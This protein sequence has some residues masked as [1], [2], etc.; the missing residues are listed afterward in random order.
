MTDDAAILAEFACS[1]D[2]DDLPESVVDRVRLVVSDTVGAII[3]GVDT[4]AVGRLVDRLASVE[5][6]PGTVLGREERLHPASAAMVNGTAGTVLELDE[7]HK[8]AAGHPAIHVIPALFATTERTAMSVDGPRFTAAVVAGYEVAVRVGEAATPLAPG[9]HPHGVW[10]VVGAVAGLA[11]LL[12]LDEQTATEAIRMAPNHAQHTR[13]EAAM[14]GRT[15][16]NTYAGMV[17]PDAIAVVDQAIA[18][19]TGLTD[20]LTAHLERLAHEGLGNIDTGSLGTRWTVENGY[21]KRH[22]ACR[23]T[24]P[25]IDAIDQLEQ[26]GRLLDGMIERIDI[27]TY[28]TAASLTETAPESP[29]AARFSLPFAVATRIHHGHANKDAFEQEAITSEVIDLAERVTIKS[30]EEFERAL[31]DERGARV[32]VTLADGTARPA[33]V[34]YAKGD[35][36]NPFGR[37]DLRDKFVGLVEPVLGKED[38]ATLWSSIHRLPDVAPTALVEGTRPTSK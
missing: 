7:G 26:E 28:P 14:S 23:Y 16:R 8:H 21:F 22:A 13:F 20:G 31:P 30:T 32:C 24:H 29:L 19:F 35:S 33:K 10:G 25:A 1:L 4:P 15:I 18:G 37:S 5:S 17:A 38:T 3:G 11:K 2:A 6:G 34:P 12:D 36:N 27:E 9:Y